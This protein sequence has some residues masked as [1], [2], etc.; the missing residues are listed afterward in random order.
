MA[1]RYS[2]DTEV[3]VHWDPR[4]KVY[5]GRVRDPHKRW[6]GEVGARYAYRLTGRDLDSSEAYDDA[7]RRLIQAAERDEGRFMA[8][9]SAGRIRIRRVFQAP[10]PADRGPLRLTRSG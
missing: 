8:E 1:K 9:R 10:C 5:S 6:S 4:S 3:R 7:A 2:G